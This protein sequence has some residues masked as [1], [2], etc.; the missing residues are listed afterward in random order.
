MKATI[1]QGNHIYDVEG[2]PE[3]IARFAKSMESDS[4]PLTQRQVAEMPQLRR[5]RSSIEDGYPT[6]NEFQNE[7][8]SG[9]YPVDITFARILHNLRLP[10]PK[11]KDRSR[12][13]LRF[14]RARNNLIHAKV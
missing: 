6:I 13:Y 10:L 5:G 2:S 12:V 7:L 3:E 14:K 11:G 1:R 8:K 9:I 4:Q